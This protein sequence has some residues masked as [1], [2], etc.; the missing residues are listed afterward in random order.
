MRITLINPPFERYGG[1]KGHGGKAMPL[2]LCYIAAY[3]KKYAKN[4]RDINLI[5]AEAEGLTFEQIACKI[6]IQKPDIVGLTSPT[7]VFNNCIEIAD[8]IKYFLSDV[9]IILGGPHPSIFP[10]ES[11][12][13]KSIDYCVIGEGEETFCKLANTISDYK[14]KTI[15]IS[16][17]YE[18]LKNIDGLAYKYKDIIY[19]NNPRE[20]IPDINIIP[21]PDRELIN[22][23]LYYPPPTKRVSSY[24]STSLV[25]SRGCVYH[26]SYC[27]A[28]KLWRHKVRYRS[29]ENV[30]D[31]IELCAKKYNL[32][33]F[34]IHDEWFTINKERTIELCRK[35]IE[36]KIDTA[37]VCMSR[38]HPLDEEILS[39]MKKA[40]CKKINFGFESGSQK[41]LDNIKH[42]TTIEQGY[43]AAELCHK[44]GIKIGANFMIGA[45]GETNETARQ[46]I[47]FAKKIKPDTA[48]FFVATPYPGTEF[49]EQAK[50]KGYLRKDVK[51]SDFT[52]VSD[53]Q[54]TLNLPDMNSE[55]IRNWVKR[56]Y[57]EFYLR[58]AFMLEKIKGLK[59]F[60][61]IKNLYEGGKIFLR[62]K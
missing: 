6:K 26:C 33:E 44:T 25:T 47:E 55:Q 16:K 1:M 20:L 46:T 38:V 4:S 42:Q 28:T 40:G 30:I 49:Y 60:Q 13:E 21:F 51:W 29:V 22:R 31:E 61:G 8:S 27:I 36:T 43:K 24:N 39:W 56:A 2:N 18:E 7:P 54:P 48:A 34:N 10:R 17:F 59:N 41:I 35:I 57:R 12:M 52:L 5:D 23:D 50:E 58:P 32:S 11:L 19:V 37:W 14:N 3:A 45:I 62:V 9:S 15:E 53:F